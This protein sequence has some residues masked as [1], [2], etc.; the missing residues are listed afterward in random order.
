MVLRASL[1]P[2]GRAR[3]A[4]AG[5]GWPPAPPFVWGLRLW[6]PAGGTDE[7]AR[8]L[9]A[10]PGP[11]RA[12]F[13]LHGMDGLPEEAVARLLGQAGVAD[14]ADAVREALAAWRDWE[15]GAPG[16]PEAG[17]GAGP[18][19]REAR[20]ATEPGALRGGAP[21]PGRGAWAG[22]GPVAGAAGGA[23]FRGAAGSTGGQAGGNT[24]GET[25]LRGPDRAEFDAA[26]VSARPTGLLRRRRRTRAGWTAARPRW[27][28]PPGSS[29]PTRRRPAPRLRRSP[30][31]PPPGRQ[32]LS[33]HS[34]L[35][36]GAWH[37]LSP[38]RGKAH[39]RPVRGLPPGTPRART[40][41]R[42]AALR[43]TT[44]M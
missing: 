24:A 26:V 28:W 21:P 3:L 20:S 5:L 6:P 31:R 12:A 35:P 22:P 42:G 4:E 9:G 30:D 23:G 33:S 27:P 34:R 18:W 10:A 19:A 7:P 32:G 15:G 1:A 44:G 43:A 17:P 37:A 14:P 29:R 41:R 2:T 16:R 25:L 8:A 36:R 39:V 38:H 40:R 11:V 13:V